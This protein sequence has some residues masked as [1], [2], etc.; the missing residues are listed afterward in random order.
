MRE[1]RVFLDEVAK[2]GLR[3][4]PALSQQSQWENWVPATAARA[5]LFLFV[6]L[7]VLSTGRTRCK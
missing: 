1:A 4:V 6:R 5:S 3:M 2:W 7:R